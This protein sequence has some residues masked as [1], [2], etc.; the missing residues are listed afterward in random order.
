MANRT[1]ELDRMINKAE[2]ALQAACGQLTGAG[3][4]CSPTQSDN[5][6]AIIKGQ[7]AQ[8]DLLRAKKSNLIAGMPEDFGFK[9]PI[10]IDAV[11][12]ARFGEMQAKLNKRFK[13]ECQGVGKYL[14]EEFNRFCDDTVAAIQKKI[15]E[16][17]TI[18]KELESRGVRYRGVW[19][20]SEGYSRGDMVT[21][22]GS[23]WH[24]TVDAATKEPTSGSGGE[25][26]LAVKKGRDGKDA[27]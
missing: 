3:P 18:R 10:D 17:D 24:C 25:W 2:A 7:E 19:Q 27:R 16:V 13:A 1:R 26:Q 22:D 15:D 4:D 8:L 5:L 21:N 20:A 12:N 6:S 11:I 14:A 23:I 9:A